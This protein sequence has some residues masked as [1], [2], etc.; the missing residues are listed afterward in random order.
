MQI[1]GPGPVGSWNQF[2]PAHK[3]CTSLP[4]SV[5]AGI[6]L[7]AETVHGEN[8]YTRKSA[9]AANQGFFFFFKRELVANLPLPQTY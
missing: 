4:Y 9:N 6:T 5:L 3:S 2:S 8:T 1:P 7:A